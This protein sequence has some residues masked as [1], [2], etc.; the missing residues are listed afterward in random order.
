MGRSRRFCQTVDKFPTILSI[1][2]KG[3]EPICCVSDQVSS[4]DLLRIRRQHLLRRQCQPRTRCPPLSQSPTSAPGSPQVSSTRCVNFLTGVDTRSETPSSCPR[5]RARS[6]G[7]NQRRWRVSSGTPDALAQAAGRGEPPTPA[8]P[9]SNR[10][11]PQGTRSSSNPGLL[12][13]HSLEYP[14]LWGHQ[15]SVT[16]VRT[17]LGSLVCPNSESV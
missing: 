2:R 12:S 8:A 11:R 7:V 10:V 15:R 4:L 16:L 13:A 3:R 1:S 9:G 6:R 17:A 14:P 5:T